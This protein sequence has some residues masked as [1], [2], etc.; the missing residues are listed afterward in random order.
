MQRALLI[1]NPTAGRERA[2]KKAAVAETILSDAGWLIDL[3]A[4]EQ[5]GDAEK[6]AAQ[7]HFDY[8]TVIASGG[9]GTLHEVI[10]GIGLGGSNIDLGIIPAG[11]TN[12]FARALKIPMDVR[13]AC[14]VIAS[15]RVQKTDLGSINGRLFINIAGGGILT[16]ITYEVPSKLKTYLGQLAY[17]AKSIE[18]LPRLKPVKVRLATPEIVFEDEIMLFLTANSSSVGGFV[19]LAPGASLTD[20]LLDLIVVKRINLAEFLQLAAMALYGD[21]INHPKVL[22]LQTPYVEI[23]ST[24]IISL[25]TDGEYAGQ[26]PCKIQAHPQLVNIIVPA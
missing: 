19:H 2:T 22:Y 3:Y 6:A 26:L 24:E 23:T 18:E 4:T 13:Q 15:G 7:A 16:N 14:R 11:T 8:D 17:Y 5:A 9:D 10:N 25:N 20:G 12:D 1:Y 21:H